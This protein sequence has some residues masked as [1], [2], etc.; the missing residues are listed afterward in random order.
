MG[1]AD[2]QDRCAGQ[3]GSAACT[4]QIPQ[5]IPTDKT[6]NPQSKATPPFT[7]SWGN[8]VFDPQNSLCSP[9]STPGGLKLGFPWHNPSELFRTPLPCPAPPGAAETSPG[10]VLTAGAGS[11]HTGG[12]SKGWNGLESPGFV[13]VSRMGWAEGGTAQCSPLEG[14]EPPQ[15]PQSCQHLPL[16]PSSFLP[17]PFPPSFSILCSF[18]AQQTHLFLLFSFLSPSLP[19]PFPHPSLLHSSTSVSNLSHPWQTKTPFH[20]QP[21]SAHCPKIQHS[22]TNLT[23]CPETKGFYS[24]P[25][26]PEVQTPLLFIPKNLCP[27]QTKNTHS[28]M[29]LFDQHFLKN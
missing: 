29:T 1:R 5:H 19:S 12:N 3:G 26:A 28:Q 2:V 11:Q 21:L 6:F 10:S 8:V 18:P 16:Q 27:P 23:L 24:P 14:Q 22:Y 17:S 4:A 20:F 15:T 13:A 25:F 7:S 9:H